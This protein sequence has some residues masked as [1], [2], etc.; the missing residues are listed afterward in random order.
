MKWQKLY[1]ESIQALPKK[2]IDDETRV[3]VWTENM[4]IVANPK[5][6][7]MEYLVATKQWELIKLDMRSSINEKDADTKC[8]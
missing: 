3:A 7:P 4:V 5:F 6:A 1:L 8:S 2:F